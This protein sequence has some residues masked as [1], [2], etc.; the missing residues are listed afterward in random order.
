MA[1]RIGFVGSGGIAN[2]HMQRL[3]TLE[4]AKMVAFSDVDGGR[5]QAAAKQYGGAAYTDSK[6][7]LAKEDLD[8]VFV[9]VPPFAHTDQELA[10]VE[11]GIALFVEKPIATTVE[12]A[13]EIGEAIESKGVVNSVGYHFRYMA[14]TDSAKAALG[15]RE[16]GFATGSW[17]GGMPGV[18][19][20][21]VMAESG[22]QMVEQSTHIFDLARYMLGEVTE[23]SAM[24]RT[25]LM[26]DVSDYDVHDAAV[27]NLTFESGAVANI[28]S[29]CILQVGGKVGLDI[30]TRDLVLRMGS[31]RVE[32]AEKG[33][34]EIVES[35]ND[36]YL[37]EDRIF[38]EAVESGDGSKIRSPYHDAIRTLKV[39]LAANRSI[40]EGRPISV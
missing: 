14:S 35:E 2:H 29:S 21:R 13:E 3:A 30:Y 37:D 19:W 7:M 38:L 28:V 22:G 31:G 27:T 6:E 34:T 16:V 4:N 26:T 1:V 40:A 18:H 10:A 11:K 32:I 17:T 12:K 15:D 9:C 5:A 25:G 20:W 8:A 39:T 24:A 33:R 23:V 36:P